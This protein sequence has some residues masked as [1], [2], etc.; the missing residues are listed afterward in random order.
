MATICIRGGSISAGHL[1]TQSYVDVLKS[2]EILRNHTIINISRVGDSSFEGVWQFE[3]VLSHKPDILIIHFGM[4]DIFRPVYRSEFKENLVR[5]VQKAREGSINTL[6]LV[7][8][9]LVQN[10]HLMERVESITNTVRDVAFDMKCYL[11]TVHIE[12]MN[13]MYET[14]NNITTLLTNDERYPNE[15]GHQ[16]IAQAIKRKLTSVLQ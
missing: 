13:Y 12:W 16:L 14:G 2:D 7:T 15:L 6:I 9:H 10:P 8:L 5:M 1:A 3:Q 4:D 11:A